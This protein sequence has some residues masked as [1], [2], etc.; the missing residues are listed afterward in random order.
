LSL[1]TASQQ[2]I[3]AALRGNG[4]DDPEHWAKVVTGNGPYPSDDPTFGKLRQVLIQYRAE[5]ANIEKTM[6]ALR[7]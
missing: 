5:P 1:A 6:N 3:S 2:D 4:V 7:P